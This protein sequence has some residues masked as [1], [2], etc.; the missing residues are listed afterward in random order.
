MT[1]KS[2]AATEWENRFVKRLVELGLESWIAHAIFS[3]GFYDLTDNP[4]N[5][6]EDEASYWMADT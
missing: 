1:D 3:V 6:A 2:L 4:E 5:A